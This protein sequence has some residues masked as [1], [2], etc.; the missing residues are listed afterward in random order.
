MNK[1]PTYEELETKIK[2]LENSL[3]LMDSLKYDI[4]VNN[5]FLEKLFDTIPNPIF[6]KDKNGVYQHCNDAF[7]KTILGIPK[8][9]IIGKTLYDLTDIVPKMYADIYS[10]KD[11]ELF[12][13]P[14]E[15]F[16][17]GKVKC[18]DGITRDYHFYKSSFVIDGEILALVGVMLDVSDYKKTLNELDE[19]N[20]LLNDI[21]ITDY[22]TGL[23]NR[24]YFQDIFEKKLSLAIRHGHK[25]SFALIDIDYFKNYN[26]C[27]GH[28]EGD[29]VLQ[30]ISKVLKNTLTRPNDYVFR[31]GGEEFAILFEV[32][33][34]NDGNVLI[35]NLRKKVEE[36]KIKSGNNSI[37]EYLTISIGLGN[38]KKVK[39]G[40][41]ENIVYAEVDKLLYESKNNGRN[42]ISIKN[43]II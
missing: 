5:F 8:E 17:E 4:K 18:S 2:E 26:D 38:I 15:Q 7:S 12:V 29:V 13:E 39:L 6:Y 19:K 34:K 20:K 27:Y 37:S 9:E 31:V 24:R 1:K 28:H 21:S 30:K 14:K 11:S 23:Y 36:L 10:Q 33:C 32:D 35:Q 43:I 25:F 40:T 42:Q 3:S 22:L 16:Y 41:S